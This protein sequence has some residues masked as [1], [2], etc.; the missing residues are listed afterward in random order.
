[1]KSYA[2]KTATDMIVT[3]VKLM[4]K[5]AEIFKSIHGENQYNTMIVNLLCQLPGV[6]RSA[7]SSAGSESSTE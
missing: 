2:S 3:Q 1:M 7:G 4:R 6:N 5:N